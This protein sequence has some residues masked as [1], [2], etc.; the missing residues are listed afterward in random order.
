MKRILFVDDEPNILE[1]LA[2]ML[3]PLR[4][5]W[6]MA[7]AKS[8]EEALALMDKSPFDVIVSDMRMPGMDGATLL[9]EVMNR[10]PEVIRFVLSGE[11]DK[12]TIIRTLGNTHQFLA[13]P[14]DAKTLKGCVDR[15]FGLRGLLNSDS[16]KQL[17]SQIDSLPPMPALYI[18][19]QKELESADASVSTV[20]SLI[21]SDLAM[22]SKIL[23]LVNSA[24]FGLRQRANTATQAVSLLGLNTIKS[25]VLMAGIFSHA[26]DKPL[27]ERLSLETLHTHSMAVG[28]FAQAI[29]K[30]ASSDREVV[31]NALTAGLL[32]DSGILILAMSRPEAYDE[33]LRISTADNLP[34]TR[35]E[36]AALGCTHAEVGAYLFGIWGL[37]DTIVEAVAFHHFPGQCLNQ[38]FSPLTAVHVADVLHLSHAVDAEDQPLKNLDTAY[39]EGLGMTDHLPQWRSVCMKASGK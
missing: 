1:G 25:L 38:A 20:G 39:V 19:L 9:T 32:H 29:M 16:V 5:E 7:F 36:S 24:F 18:Q 11:S 23:Q 2:R 31:S 35:V 26:A 14:C 22:T 37:P 33:V 27:A 10:H 12:E 3:F 30:T 15:A 13:K 28:A 34:L 8:G 21:E 4:K 17:V 6:Q